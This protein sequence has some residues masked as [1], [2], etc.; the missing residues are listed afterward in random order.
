MQL[1]KPRAAL[2]DWDNTLVD[3]LAAIHKAYG[4]TLHAMGMPAWSY[5]KTCARVSHSLRETF[6]G[7]FGERWQEASDVFYDAYCAYHLD[8]VT[9]LPGAVELLSVLSEAG[10]YLG[11][12]S[13]KSGDILRR[14][15]QHLDWQHYF[16]RVVGATDAAQDKPALAPVEMALDGSGVAP[17]EDVWFIGDNA[18]DVACAEAT[19]C[20]PFI[21]RG[22][23]E[24]C[25]DAELAGVRWRFDGRAQLA[26]VVQRL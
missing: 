12:V 14:E 17:G 5:E 7:L 18:V 22:V 13:N 20:I 21:L 1:S 19:G 25:D 3:S 16:G 6:P 24:T 10:V 8:N 15:V 26:A 11:V 2:F 4:E 23:V 9:P